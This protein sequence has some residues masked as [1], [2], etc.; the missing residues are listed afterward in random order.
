MRESRFLGD[1]PGR[2]HILRAGPLSLVYQD[3]EIRYLRL[4]S[5]E[6]VRRI[7]VSVRDENWATILPSVSELQIQAQDDAFQ[8]SF[9]ARHRERKVDFVWKGRISGDSSGH[10]Q[11]SFDGIAQTSFLQSR[12][13]I[14]VLHPIRE[15]AGK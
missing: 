14:C 8:V 1:A 5:H 13:G 4:G 2:R 9:D 7:Y 3:G 11:F 6:I 10:V 15:F 12:V